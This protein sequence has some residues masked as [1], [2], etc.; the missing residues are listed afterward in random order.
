[1]EGTFKKGDKDVTSKH[2]SAR[3]V[4]KTIEI[5]P[6]QEMIEALGND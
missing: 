4:N 3:C 6:K 1:M 5:K 2:A